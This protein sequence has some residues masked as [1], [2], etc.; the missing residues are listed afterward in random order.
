M[1]RRRML[2][3]E[4][5]GERMGVKKGWK[6]REVLPSSSFPLFF[7][8]TFYPISFLYPS[9]TT[10]FIYIFFGKVFQSFRIF[11][12]W[13]FQY[14]IALYK[15]SVGARRGKGTGGLLL[16]FGHEKSWSFALLKRQIDSLHSWRHDYDFFLHGCFTGHFGAGDWRGWLERGI[17]GGFLFFYFLFLSF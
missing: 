16:F 11:S 1:N 15:H 10:F 14:N 5:V 4:R 12:F 6:E 13:V 3:V 17:E 2:F 8:P 7:L 9:S